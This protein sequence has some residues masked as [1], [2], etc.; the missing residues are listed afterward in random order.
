MIENE[1]FDENG[2]KIV[3]NGKFW[4]TKENFVE[5]LENKNESDFQFKNGRNW[6]KWPKLGENWK[7]Q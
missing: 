1:I 4:K 5:K 2:M 3:K 6:K 7:I